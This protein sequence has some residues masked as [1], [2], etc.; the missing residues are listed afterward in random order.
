MKA[1]PFH[2]VRRGDISEAVGALA[3]AGSAGRVLGGGQGLLPLLH[4]RR[5][6]CST[7]VDISR[8]DS[9]SRVETP[10]DGPLV[11]SAL[12]AQ[13]TCESQPHRGLGVATA[14]VAAIQQLHGTAT[15]E[16]PSGDGAGQPKN[17]RGENHENNHR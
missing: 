3:A 10:P 1:A 6:P 17:Q 15:P 13:R 11:L 4:R 16:T 9:L 14:R 12:T 8:P 5:I 7:L 2:D